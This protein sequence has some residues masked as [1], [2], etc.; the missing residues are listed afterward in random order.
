MGCIKEAESHFN[1]SNILEDDVHLTQDKQVPQ[2][3]IPEDS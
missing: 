3:F 2:Y 1:S